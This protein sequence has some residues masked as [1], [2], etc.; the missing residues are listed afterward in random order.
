MKL[1]KCTITCLFFVIFFGCESDQ[2]KQ[3]EITK[4]IDAVYKNQKNFYDIPLDTTLF[5]SSI[6]KEMKNIRHITELDV[7]R[8]Q[9]SDFPTD[10]PFQFEGSVF[11]SLSD[12]YSK[13]TITTITINNNIAYV[14]IDFEY[15]STPKVKWTDN[16][17]LI[18]NNGWKIDNILFSKIAG[19]KDLKERLHYAP[20]ED[21]VDEIIHSSLKD[22]KGRILS[23]R[24]NTT[25]DI[26]TVDFL[27]EV[28][29]LMGQ[30][31]ASG[32]WYANGE[33]ELRGKGDQV[34]LSKSGK[35]IFTTF[36][37]ISVPFKEAQNYFLLTNYK[38]APLHTVKITNQKFFDTL[39]GAA[40]IMGKYG[41]PTPIDFNSNYII[42]IIDKTSNR[43]K[44]LSVKS[45]T[46]LKNELTIVMF[47]SEISKS[48]YVSRPIKLLIVPK[49]YQGALKL[50]EY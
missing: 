9:N 21:D 30:R 12:G 18:N 45:I 4:I 39:F 11:T 8:V 3:F 36:E 28:F 34:S 40:T 47:S 32:M 15:N 14:T 19:C 2:K 16:V 43:A 22:S 41:K 49:T 23:M 1:I 26:V 31:P 37:E 35:V 42:A 7:K 6:I 46:Q 50:E 24:F 29:V 5:S 20:V 10:K 44:E 25:K 13:Y 17:V 27:N 33:Y 38:E 48:T